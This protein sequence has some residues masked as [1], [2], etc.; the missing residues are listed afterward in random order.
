[1]DVNKLSLGPLGTNCYVIS[2]DKESIIFDPGGDADQIVNWIEKSQ[3]NPVAIC[4]THAHFDHIGAVEPLREQYEIPVYLHELEENWLSDPTL[5]GSSFFPVEDI[6]VQS[7]DAFLEEG[8]M[9]LQSFE[10]EILHTPGHSPGGVAFVFNREKK[11]IGG[12][13]LFHHG[14]GR[15]DLPGGD[16]DTLINS[17]KTK[18]F[19]YEDDYEVFPGHGPLTTIGNEKRENPFL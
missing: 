19:K 11:I 18:L 12:D 6:V 7:C 1:M 9:K 17:I 16:F 15:T 5:N 14:I 8:K 10:F 2:N 4:L 13:S 3:L